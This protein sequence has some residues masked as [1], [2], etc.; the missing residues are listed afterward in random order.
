MGSGPSLINEGI[1]WVLKALMRPANFK[2]NA[3][4][5]DIPAEHASFSCPCRYLPEG[6]RKPKK[7]QT[8]QTTGIMNL[9]QRS[10]V[11]K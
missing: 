8:K 4:V 10:T 2:E 5:S 9:S 3:G 7:P 11:Q 6:E 1:N